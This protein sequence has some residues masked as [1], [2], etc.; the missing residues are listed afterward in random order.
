MRKLFKLLLAAVV[1]V[2][3]GCLDYEEYLVLNKDGSGSIKIHYSID[4]SYLEQMQQLSEQ[5]GGEKQSM[6]D[7]AK[8]MMPMSDF[9]EGAMPA[10]SGVKLVYFKPS[11]TDEAV[12]WDM[13]FS[14][15]NFKA[16]YALE[17]TP[18]EEDTEPDSPISSGTE[19][20]FTKQED[21][22]WLVCPCSLMP[23]AVTKPRMPNT[24]ATAIKKTTIT[25]MKN[26]M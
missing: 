7:M 11:E 5:M 4:K 22:T 15:D 25:V 26:L 2:T 23:V 19:I 10:E 17:E 14:F 3:A 12:A 9:E 24:A 16:F 1:L 20:S 13:K 6:A 18:S 21:G 8:E